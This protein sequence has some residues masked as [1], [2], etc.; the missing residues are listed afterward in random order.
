MI[1]IDRYHKPVPSSV[2]LMEEQC[3]WREHACRSAGFGQGG[4]QMRGKWAKNQKSTCLSMTCVKDL[5]KVL[6]ALL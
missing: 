2:A 5:V 6:V 1:E 3:L 4:G